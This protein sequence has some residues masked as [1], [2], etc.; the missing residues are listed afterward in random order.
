MW[1][2]TTSYPCCS[3]VVWQWEE[4]G[5]RAEVLLP[6]VVPAV[7]A[8]LRAPSLPTGTYVEASPCVWWGADCCPCELLRAVD[9]RY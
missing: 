4:E 8:V 9:I 7:E 3:L 2:R 5:R 1:L 6:V